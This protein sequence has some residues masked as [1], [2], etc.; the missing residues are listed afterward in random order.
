MCMCLCL[1]GMLNVMCVSLWYAECCM[2]LCGMLNV[3]CMCL[4]GSL[5]VVSMWLTECH[6]SVHAE[7]CV[8]VCLS[9]SVHA[10]DHHT[11]II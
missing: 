2:C 8:S 9:V 10:F 7:F 1:Y 4:C 11:I 3:V 5:N 6:V